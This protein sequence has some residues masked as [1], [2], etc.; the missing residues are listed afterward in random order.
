MSKKK[1][2]IVICL[3]TSL[4]FPLAAQAQRNNNPNLN[5]FYMGRQ[6]VQ[7]IDES[8]MIMNRSSSADGGAPMNG[9]LPNRP[10]PLPHAGWQS[11]TQA[12]PPGFASGLPKVINGVPPKP[13]PQGPA[14]NK[15]KAGALGAAN[16]G[17]TKGKP[18]QVAGSPTGVS[19]YKPYATYKPT[20]QAASGA[21]GANNQQTST[22][23]KGSIL[24]WARGP[25]RTY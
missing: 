16:K 12:Q 22:H 17:K 4:G 25:H 18:A 19:A 10:L 6:Q 9:S 5:H 14:G 21:A 2:T 3:A 7:I 8:P 24:H 15:G 11:Y 23:V 13:V 1:S 20:Q